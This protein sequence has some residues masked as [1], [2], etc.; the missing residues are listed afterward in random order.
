M[1]QYDIF[2]SYKRKSL[3]TANNL[4]YRLTTR[5]YSTFFDLEEMGRDN[6]NVQLL[7]Y[8]EHAKDVFVILEEGSLDGC[9]K[10][11]WE[12]EDWFCR[13]VAYALEKQKNIIPVLI[14]GYKMPSAEKLPDKLKELSLKNAPEFSFSF[15]EEYLNKLIEKKYITSESN[16]NRQSS[17][18][19]FYSD[20][21]CTVYQDGRLVCSLS[22]KANEPFYLPISRRGD[23]VFKCK[24]DGSK[25]EQTRVETIND[26]EE[27]IVKITW[28]NNTARRIGKY[29]LLGFTMLMVASAFYVFLNNRLTEKVMPEP[30]EFVQYE[31]KR[32]TYEELIGCNKEHLRLLRNEIFARHGYIFADKELQSF[33]ER[34]SWYHPV[35]RDVGEIQ[36]SEIEQQNVM[37][38]KNI[39]RMK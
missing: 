5:G 32:Y 1:E 12:K 20:E 2:I 9:M 21:D 26:S 36:L 28:G 7:S 29:F 16:I 19:K 11:N 23:F 10:D 6:F 15:F 4:Y 38:L 30:Q 31:D 24:R 39:E 18:F 17:V 27:K 8:I 22:G 14:G 3:P 33:F 13:E 35:T 34:Q 37:L 25:Q